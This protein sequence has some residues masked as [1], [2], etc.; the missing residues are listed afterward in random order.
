MAKVE[1]L[2]EK[3]CKSFGE[4]PHWDDRTGQLLFVDINDYS[5]HR[6]TASTGTREK[7]TFGE[8]IGN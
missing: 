6:W 5:V 8:K 2:I 3:C 4:G 1:T 7:H